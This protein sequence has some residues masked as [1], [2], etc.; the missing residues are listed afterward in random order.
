MPLPKDAFT[1]R[2]EVD[3]ADNPLFIPAPEG[4]THLQFRRFIG[5]PFCDIHLRAFEMRY[6]EIRNAGI[7]VIV[8][9]RSNKEELNRNP[10]DLP[11]SIFLDP[12]GK[13]YTEMSIKSGLRAILN[14]TALTSAFPNLIRTIMAGRFALPQYG[15]MNKSL[16]GNPADFLLVPDGKILDREYATSAAGG[17]TVNELLERSKKLAA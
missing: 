10:A 15:R 5:C 16:L 8:V 1:P 13:L 9:F 11:Y 2:R 3:A 17:W 14:V 6:D 7:N 12:E 4:I